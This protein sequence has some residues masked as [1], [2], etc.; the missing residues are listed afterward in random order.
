MIS[1]NYSVFLFNNNDRKMAQKQFGKFESK[2]KVLK[3]NANPLNTDSEVC[4]LFL[5]VYH[6]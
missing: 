1:L 4:Y 6:A 5:Y 2:V 3:G